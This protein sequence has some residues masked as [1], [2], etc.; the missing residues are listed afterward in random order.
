M[1][2]AF[3]EL[4]AEERRIYIDQAA[5]RRNV[6]Q[7]LIHQHYPGLASYGRNPPLL[8]PTPAAG[9]FQSDTSKPIGLQ[10]ISLFVKGDCPIICWKS[11][12]EYA[13]LRSQRKIHLVSSELS[14]P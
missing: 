3:L 14:H 9:H 11:S 2:L 1:K 12:C 5:I 10:L 6:S 4:P 8:A 13:R 7:P